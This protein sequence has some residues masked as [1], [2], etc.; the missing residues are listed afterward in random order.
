MI[1]TMFNLTL[2]ESEIIFFDS[3][4]WERSRYM[5]RNSQ[6]PSVYFQI[7][8]DGLLVTDGLTSNLGAAKTE[9]TKILSEYPNAKLKAYHLVRANVL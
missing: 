8:L 5:L 2:G 7:W 3:S 9:Y 1:Y 4:A 6:N